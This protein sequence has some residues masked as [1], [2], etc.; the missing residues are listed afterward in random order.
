MVMAHPATKGTAVTHSR[1]RLGFLAAL[2]SAL[3]LM[4][5]G[6]AN[7]ALAHTQLLSSDPAK[8]AHLDAAP[9]LVHLTFSS[10]VGEGKATVALSVNEGAAVDLPVSTDGKLV[11]AEVPADAVQPSSESSSWR[12]EYRILSSDGHP[13]SGAITFTVA[14]SPDASPEASEEPSVEPSAEPS[15][16]PSSDPT[17]DT[18]PSATPVAEEAPGNSGAKGGSPVVWIVGAVLLAAAAAGSAVVLRR[19]NAG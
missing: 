14:G 1:R 11:T 9:T 8:G 15:A 12:V 17:T 3:L 6:L 19:R 16:E 7:P 5:L 4:G 2:I 18:T 13:V 10:R